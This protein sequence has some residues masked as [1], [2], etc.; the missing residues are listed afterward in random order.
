MP[1]EMALEPAYPN[2]FNP[3]TNLSYTLVNRRAINYQ[4]MI[5]MVD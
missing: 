3:T 2:P 5:L 1:T 4:Y